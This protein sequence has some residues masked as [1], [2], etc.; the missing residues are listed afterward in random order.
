MKKALI[1][2]YDGTFKTSDEILKRNID[3]VIEYM[4]KDNIFGIST[5]RSYESIC[6]EKEKYNFCFDYLSCFNANTIFDK[7]LTLLYSNCINNDFPEVIFNFKNYIDY[8]VGRD[9][10]SL[11]DQYDIVEY[12][13]RF[14]NEEGRRLFLNYINSENQYTYYTDNKDRLIIHVFSKKND[15]SYVCN[16]ISDIENIDKSNIYT[17]GDGNNDL[18]MIKHFN[19]YAMSSSPEIV[20]NSSLGICDNFYELVDNIDDVKKRVRY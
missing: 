8:A 9:A 18:E 15:K 19:G 2:D 7:D 14:H 3:S 6:S 16:Y 5:G 13:I 11:I 17:I 1:T 10:Y 12:V 4:Y 20:R